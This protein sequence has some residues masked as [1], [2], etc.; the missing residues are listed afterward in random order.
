MS[1]S[2]E[3]DKPFKFVHPAL[4]HPTQQR[5]LLKPDRDH[6]NPVA[7]VLALALVIGIGTLGYMIIEDWRLL[8]ALYMTII[9]L[10]TIGYQEVQPLSDAGRIFTMLLIIVG[11][12]IVAIVFGTIAEHLVSRQFFRLYGQ[13]RMNER[14]AKLDVHTIICGFGRV[15]RTAA[16]AL[17]HAGRAI[18]VVERD[19]IKAQEAAALGYLVAV[20]DASTEETLRQ[21]R[22]E[23]ATALLS[24]LPKD[25]D[26]LYV[27][28]TSRE[29]SPNLFIVSRCEEEIGEKRLLRAGANRIMSPYRVGG[30]KIAEALLRPNVTD[31]LDLAISQG[32]K[33]L[34][35]EEIRIPDHSP[36]IGRS[37]QTAE[38]RQ[39]TNVIVAA[40]ISPNGEMSFNPDNTQ[41]AA[42]K[43]ETTSFTA[44]DGKNSPWSRPWALQGTGK[45]W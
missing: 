27:I 9:T 44:P 28:L 37:L 38:L 14:I 30:L 34:Q 32:G 29:M 26:N 35:I 23:R 4:L 8:D 24:L 17:R 6:F 3:S 7:A 22:V 43:L 40:I 21:V 10:G 31:F 39:R 11:V 15:A 42:D 36:L 33:H 16:E 1:R 12:G 5:Y 19:P 13:Q 25:S 20:G 41:D 2:S 18:V 45:P